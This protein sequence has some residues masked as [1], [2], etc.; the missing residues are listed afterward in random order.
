M[1]GESGAGKTETTKIIM[2]YLATVAGSAAAVKSSARG[3]DG[4]A[5][6]EDSEAIEPLEKQV[7]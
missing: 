3:K 5:S 7:C 1:S 4:K 6:K 2:A